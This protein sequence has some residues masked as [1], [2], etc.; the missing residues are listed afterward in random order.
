[1]VGARQSRMAVET[2]AVA[3]G[4]PSRLR[5]RYLG[6]RST[7]SIGGTERQDGPSFEGK[8]FEVE[9]AGDDVRISPVGGGGL[10][11]AEVERVGRDVSEMLLAWRKVQGRRLR[12][13]EPIGGDGGGPTVMLEGSRGGAAILRVKVATP[14]ELPVGLSMDA[15]LEGQALVD[16]GSGRLREARTEG[17]GTLETAKVDRRGEMVLTGTGSY[18]QT[19]IVSTTPRAAVSG[20]P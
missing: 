19:D 11:A 12:V 4:Q 16:L 6:Y 3:A 8:A 17:A 1:V 5:L 15:R 20:A 18:V 14:L 13:G 2:L 7:V 10:T 9:L